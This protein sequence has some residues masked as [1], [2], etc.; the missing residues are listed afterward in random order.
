MPMNR[1]ALAEPNA[2]MDPS[3]NPRMQRRRELMMFF[4]LAFVI[5]PFVAVAVVGG[6]GFMVWMYQLIA[7]PPG[8]PHV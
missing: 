7:G 6:Y 2:A 1:Q 5:W 3:L 8:P 4:F